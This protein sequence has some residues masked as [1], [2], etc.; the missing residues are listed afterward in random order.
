MSVD[1][2]DGAGIIDGEWAQSIA[3]TTLDVA[4]NAS[5]MT[6]YDLVFAY[7]DTASQTTKLRIVDGVPGAGICPVV[8]T[9]QVAGVSWAVP[10]ACVR[11]TNGAA[12]IVNA[13]ITD[14]RE[15]CQFRFSPAEM[16]D[17]VTID[18]TAAGLM[19]VADAGVDENKLTASVAGAG[20]T[21]GAGAPLA[22]NPDGLTIEAVADAVRIAATAAG[23][24]L[25]GGGAAAL[26]VNV[27]AATIV[28]VGDTLQ[29]GAITAANIADRTRTCWLGASQLHDTATDPPA[30]DAIGAQPDCA[31][32]WI[33]PTN[34]DRYV[35]G[36]WAVP[37]DFVTGAVSVKIVW[38]HTSGGAEVCRLMLTYIDAFGCGEMLTG[39][40]TSLIDDFNAV[41]ADANKRMCSILSSTIIG[42]VPGDMI[43][44]TVGR[45]GNHANDTLAGDA[46]LLGVEFSYVADM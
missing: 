20:L 40:T 13:D 36:H 23:A 45:N 32:G 25:T 39:G 34:V 21:G 7:W 18:T 42:V 16:V 17:G 9:Y 14:T 41:A 30:W 6:R 12:S 31:E 4:A 46:V 26:A 29:V 33:C 22:V 28:I 2:Q 44:F 5:G 10:L 24:G 11:V 27:D 15:F 19:E 8:T 3:D 1:V 37:A 43:D 38:S 35:V